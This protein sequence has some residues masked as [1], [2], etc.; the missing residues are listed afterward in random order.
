MTQRFLGYSAAEWCVSA[1]IRTFLHKGD[2]AWKRRKGRALRVPPVSLVRDKEVS[3]WGRNEI[4]NT[5]G[6][7]VPHEQMSKWCMRKTVVNIV[8]FWPSLPKP[9]LGL[10]DTSTYVVNPRSSS[11]RPRCA[12]LQKD[13]ISVTEVRPAKSGVVSAGYFRGI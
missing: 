13:F 10:W 7:H 9:G 12:N 1:P 3:K 4:F 11:L 5:N 8:S 6:C 2:A